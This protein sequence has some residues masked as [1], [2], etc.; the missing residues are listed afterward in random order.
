MPEKITIA[1]C[2]VEVTWL[3]IKNKIKIDSRLDKNSWLR[4]TT[5]DTG[6]KRVVVCMD[7]NQVV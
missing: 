5:C 1:S 2:S 6:L 4:I 3:S 7:K